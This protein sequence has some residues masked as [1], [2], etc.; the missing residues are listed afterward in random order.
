MDHTEVWSVKD[1][2]CTACGKELESDEFELYPR[3]PSGETTPDDVDLM[4][5]DCHERLADYDDRTETEEVLE[6][7]EREM[8]DASPE[9]KTLEYLRRIEA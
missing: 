3:N 4:C 5:P 1:N 6:E 9:R 2:V 8:P 7:I